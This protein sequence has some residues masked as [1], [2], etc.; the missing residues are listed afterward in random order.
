MPGAIGP[1]GVQGPQGLTGLMGPQGI[2]GIPG[3]DCESDCCEKYY[4]SLYS[5]MD[6]NLGVNGSATDFAKLEFLGVGTALAFD[7]SLAATLGTIKVLIA[8]IYQL[9]WDADGMLSP[10]FSSPVPFM[11]TCLI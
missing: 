2:Q 5:L 1:Q 4:L 7:W 3:K 6:Q 11:G 9:Q 10:P 8:G